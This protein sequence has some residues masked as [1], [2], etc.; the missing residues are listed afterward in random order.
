MAKRIIYHPPS[1]QAIEAYAR[2]ACE[3]LAERDVSYLSPD[4]VSGFAQFLQLTSTI[5]SLSE[6]KSGASPNRFAFGVSRDS[7][8]Y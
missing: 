3:K 1:R 6:R 8:G 5:C 7:T 2:I 4:V